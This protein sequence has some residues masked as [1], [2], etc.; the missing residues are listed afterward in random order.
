[1]PQK[2]EI[3]V[4]PHEVVLGAPKLTV[5]SGSPLDPE[6]ARASI[7][8]ASVRGTVTLSD[9]GR[10][11]TF[12][13]D[14]VLPPGP[15]TFVVGDLV[16]KRGKPISEGGEIPFFVSDSK[17]KVQPHLRVESIVRLRVDRLGTERLPLGQ[18]ANRKYVEVMKAVDRKSGKPQELAFDERGNRIDKNKLFERIEKN[19]QAKYGKLHPSLHAAIGRARGG[20]CIPV[21]VWFRVGSAEP[22]H[23]K[24]ERGETKTPPASEKAH[25][26]R[27][28]VAAGVVADLVRQH[29]ASR[30]FRVD[31][32]AP[33]VF[34]RL[35]VD[36]I[37][38]LAK[39]EEVLALF[40]HE[41]T[42]VLDLKDSMAIAQSDKVHSSLSITG[43]GV[44][45]AVYE[46]GPDDTTNLSIASQF[47]T[48][49]ATSQHARHTHGI[50]RNTE[51]NLPHGHAKGC[52]LHSANSEDLD[53]INWAA[54][55]AGCTVIS[56][57]FH[58]DS[59]QT[60]ST[61]SFDDMYKDW[62]ALHWPW[63]TILQAAG[64]G[65]SSEYVNHKGYN[66]LTV[67]N[68]DDTAA[69]LAS[70]SVFRNPS[71]AHS[72]RELPDLAANGVTVS[73][74]GLNLSGTSMAAPAAAGCTALIQQA[75]STL[76][77]WP[78]GCRAILLAGASKNITGSTWWADRQ[79]ALDASDGSGAVDGLESVRIAQSHRS[80][81]SAASRRGW[82]VGTLRS[83]DIGS[84]GQTTF[85]YQVVVP[86]YFFGARVKVAL[87]WDSLATLQDFFFFQLASDHLQ[88]DL[89][90]HVYNSRGTRV[91]YSGSWDNSYEIA[92]FSANAGETYTIKIRRWSGTEDVWYGLAWT[93]QG[94]P[95]IRPD[96]N[97]TE[98]IVRLAE[99]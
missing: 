8:V 87:A 18:H 59:E 17:A 63:P 7:G 29:G 5:R 67:G 53:A 56:Q 39:R 74:V 33:V 65:S 80:R 37:T 10:T 86:S 84:D 69:T 57:S 62:L 19:R 2:I 55:T 20:T 73:C 43:S 95:F 64:N 30:E 91:G 34:A 46:N 83:A 60:D 48:N 13:P 98:R 79:A 44:D 38:K 27:I 89:D 76:K 21:A 45:V 78:E 71:S 82:D 49:P 26:K 61:Q 3:G 31:P 14:E 97:L 77:S 23:A 75:N 52:N 16:S 96:W 88:V 81:N 85:S 24:R 93:V 36:G 68:H 11:A 15:H 51:A 66:S 58:R 28:K 25:A 40:L 94:S 35:P 72:D 90:L 32:D 22:L 42:G 70:D 12:V 4:E 92:E 41:P 50:I 9:D 47:L 99:G 54:R 1:M 6:A